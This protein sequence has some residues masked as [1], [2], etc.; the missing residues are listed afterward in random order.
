VKEYYMFKRPKKFEPEISKVRVSAAGKRSYVKKVKVMDE[1]GD[2]MKSKF[3]RGDIDQEEY[4]K[5][6]VGAPREHFKRKMEVKDRVHKQLEELRGAPMTALNTENIGNLEA[7]LAQ[8]N[9]ANTRAINLQKTL[10]TCVVGMVGLWENT[11]GEILMPDCQ[12]QSLE[13]VR[14]WDVTR[15]P[16]TPSIESYYAVT[17]MLLPLREDEPWDPPSRRKAKYN[18][19]RYAKREQGRMEDEIN[20]A[21]AEG[22]G[23]A[24]V[25]Q[26]RERKDM[27]DEVVK[28]FNAS[29]DLLRVDEEEANFYDEA[30]ARTWRESQRKLWESAKANTRDVF[31]ASYG[32]KS[33]VEVIDMV[34]A[35]SHCWCAHQRALNDEAAAEDRANGLLQ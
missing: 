28:V 4:S 31:E 22:L 5:F 14:G 13:K 35:L 33:A 11:D 29:C 20:E 2:E 6:L 16:R 30:V 18:L 10:V 24:E 3:E 25:E 27:W 8:L 12:Y 19:E 7:V 17:A 23:D 34:N 9:Q 21:I 26:W 1:K 15:W 32:Q